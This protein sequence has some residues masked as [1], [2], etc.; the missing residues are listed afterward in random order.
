M[1]RRTFLSAMTGSALVSLPAI[2][3]PKG[4]IIDL[5]WIYLRNSADQQ[6][7]RTSELLEK[8]ALP[9]VKRAGISPVGVFANLIAPAGPFILIVSSHASLAA[10]EQSTNKLSDDKEYLKA[11][12]DYNA[13]PGLGFQRIETS[14]LRGFDGIPNIDVP[15]VEEGKGPR[16]FEL[17][18]Y[19]SNNSS[20]L[21]RKV[22]MFEDGEAAIFRKVGM[23]TVF[24]GTT[25]IGRN[26]PNLTYMVGF[27]DLAHREKCW[28]DFGND[29]EWKKLRATPGLSDAEVVSNIG[30]I[31]LRPLPFSAIR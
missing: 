19:E 22:K 28:R 30:M 2:S 10:Y 15:P 1:K 25:L 4:S 11:V 14:L 5:R 23:K 12:T 17:R 9:A 31:F 16:V 6:M 26:Q 24:F 7:R 29:A 20:T 21:M 8:H 27:D 18:T 3:A 13:T